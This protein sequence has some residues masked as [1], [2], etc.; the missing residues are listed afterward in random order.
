MRTMYDR[1]E[2]TTDT[3]LTLGMTSLLGIFFGLV[4]VCGVFFGFGYSLGRHKP[5]PTVVPANADAVPA[6]VQVHKP[7]A[8]ADLQ[9]DAS[10]EEAS[11]AP[12]IKPSLQPAVVTESRP[13][14]P[15]AQ[16]AA[17]VT[18]PVTK[19]VAT[20]SGPAMMVQIAAVSRREDAEAL[21]TALRKRGYSVSIY[22]APHDSLLHVQ[23][24]PLAT[25]DEA[26]AMRARLQGDGYNAII[27]P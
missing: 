12:E 9:P 18:P 13:A 11:A 4:L 22:S 2:E 26:K 20:T 6:P 24:G 8:T 27:K 19:K 5:V 15:M 25:R 7:S 10:P 3:E 17:N 16:Q 21:V 1:E 14:R 23:V